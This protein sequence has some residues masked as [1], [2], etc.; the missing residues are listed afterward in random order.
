MMHKG[1]GGIY[2]S[3][4][5]QPPS[6]ALHSSAGSYKVSPQQHCSLGKPRLQCQAATIQQPLS[7]EQYANTASSPITLPQTPLKS[8]PLHIQQSFCSSVGATTQKERGFS[9]R[10]RYLCANT[11]SLLALLLP[12]VHSKFRV[13]LH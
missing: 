10:Q 6:M 12:Q 13:L 4:S 11:I 8:L 2:C 5:E 1:A 9:P 3:V 7:L